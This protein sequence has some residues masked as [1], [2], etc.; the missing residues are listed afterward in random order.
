M[1]GGHTPELS[2]F[3]NTS[4]QFTALNGK[5]SALEE[6]GSGESKR[7]LVYLALQQLT[8]TPAI[9]EKFVYIQ[10]V[11]KQVVCTQEVLKKL[12]Y[13]QEVLKNLVYIQEVLKVCHPYLSQ[14]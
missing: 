14:F 6:V 1:K 10:E 3:T 4:R 12:V 8:S 2:H 7:W 11:P 9:L 5:V 13:I